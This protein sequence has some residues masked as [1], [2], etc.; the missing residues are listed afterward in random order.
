MQVI[1]GQVLISPSDIT[2]AAA[3][4]FAWLRSLD[5]RLG[6][7]DTLPEAV[8]PLMDRAAELGLLHEQRHLDSLTA[9]HGPSGVVTIDSPG[10]DLDALA[11]ACEATL[12]ALH[13]RTPVVYQAALRDG[14]LRGFADFLVLDADG[15]YVVQD[16]KLAR[17]AKVPAL[18]Q[19][20]AYADILERHGIPIASH[21][22]LVLGNGLESVHDLSTVIPVY[23]ARRQ[24]LTELLTAHLVGTEVVAW[25]DVP[26]CGH[27]AVCTEEVENHRDL[28]LVAGL[29][30]T[31]RE[32]LMS[33][34][35]TT[36][37]DLAAHSGPLP[38]IGHDTYTRLQ[39][40]ARL[41][42]RQESQS[43][44]VYEVIDREPL[45]A[46]PAP[47]PG[48]IFFDFEGDPMWQDPS[49]RSWGLE[50][51]FGVIEADS[52]RFVTYWADDRRQERAALRNFLD[53]VAQ[54]RRTWPDMH[55]Y[56]YANYE[57]HTLL[58]LAGQFGTGEDEVDDLLRT[59]ALVDL[60]PVVRGA[61]QVGTRSYGLKALEPLFMP[62]H[63]EGDV[64][65]AGDSVVQYAAYCAERERGDDAAAA[66]LRQQILDY[67]EQDCRS[68]QLLRDWLLGFAG[69]EPLATAPSA[70]HNTGSAAAEEAA[71]ADPLWALAGDG[72]RTPMQQGFALLAAA[73]GFHRREDKPFWWGHFDRLDNPP[74]TWADARDALLIEDCVVLQDW[75]KPGKKNHRRHL[76]ARGT[77]QPGSCLERDRS[78][79]LLYDWPHPAGLSDGGGTSRG[80]TNAEITLVAQDA[81]SAVFEV[82]EALPKTADP[83]PQLPM[84]AAPTP[85]PS[86]KPLQR[87]IR[88]IASS[89]ASGQL[90]T[91][92]ANLL[93]R[94]PPALT[95]PGLPAVADD[96]FVGAI[97]EA[98]RAL[99]DST[100]AVQGPPG[101]GKTHTAAHVI[102][103]L[104]KDD[105]WRVGVVSQGHSAVNHLLDGI[106]KAGVDPE[107]VGKKDKPEGCLWRDVATAKT[108]EFLADHEGIGCVLGG[109]A[110]D[111][112]SDRV[113]PAQLD[114]LVVDEA[115]QFSL[116]NT[117]AVS[118][119][120]Q[121][122][123]LLGDP[124]QLPQVSQG[125]HP[126]PVDVSALG[127]LS[128]EAILPAELGYF[129]HT[130]WRMHPDLCRAVSE[131]SYAGRLTAHSCT[132]ERDLRDDQRR[133]VTAGLIAEH[134]DHQGNSVMSAEEADRIA[135]LAREALTC[136]WQPI[137]HAHHRP[138]L[139]EDVLIVAPYNAQVDLIRRTLAAQGLAGFRV[140]TVDKFQGQQAA[141]VLVSMAA[142]SHDDVP[143][144]MEF[145]LSPNRLN[146]AV[147]RAQWRTVVV[148]STRLTDYL[149]ATPERLDELG[150]FMKLL[151]TPAGEPS[152]PAPAPLRI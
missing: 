96:D 133:P 113:G 13:A 104:V 67:N 111:F 93:L 2:A 7:I 61:I 24:A 77:L 22:V 110:W 85:G 87:A 38:G 136:Q 128:Q 54:R 64:T 17:S 60:Y 4:E 58:R 57:R 80:H 1:E 55:I 23:R 143:R 115:G 30:M 123:L 76:R 32:K 149:P 42:I 116:A 94:E 44:P 141:M 8:D 47:S 26:A 40:Q 100:L 16:S 109:T 98:V 129:L 31:Q 86:A 11:E 59:G 139:P 25:G 134:V 63:R 105:G 152:S 35:I 106:V 10:G 83:F 53:Y 14:D 131:H 65:S 56:H 119:S 150:R 78:A 51:L 88:G 19:I 72:E 127:W 73:V 108:A 43:Q 91:P 122:L 41:Q 145:L 126:E 89:A 117:I 29:R 99:D 74:D 48:D 107:R 3:C 69:T 140:G 124:Q 144:G 68:T 142:S 12:A 33:A 95:T 45:T 151:T 50:Y 92:I 20:A 6:R 46:L 66:E 70:P 130:T 9:I 37:D 146:V 28:L 97:T 52:G 5:V 34:G 114:L 121:R 18:L 147:S 138:V 137:P 135:E 49:D 84:A 148:H 112:A 103:R 15:R 90:P 79:Y 81:D 21:G 82:V 132:S 75:E 62:G 101:S 102:A 36:I 39:R 125:T 120:C 71:V 27:C 118:R